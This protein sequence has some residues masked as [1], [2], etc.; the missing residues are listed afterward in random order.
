MEAGKRLL[1]AFGGLVISKTFVDVSGLYGGD[2][3]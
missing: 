3:G 1:H 2:G